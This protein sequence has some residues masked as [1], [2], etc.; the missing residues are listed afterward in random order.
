MAF[1]D[2][3]HGEGLQAVNESHRDACWSAVAKVAGS[4]SVR[5]AE[6]LVAREPNSASQWIDR[7]I[8]DYRLHPE[9]HLALEKAYGIHVTVPHFRGG[10]PLV[11]SQWHLTEDYRLAWEL[12]LF[13]VGARKYFDTNALHAFANDIDPR[14]Y[15]WRLELTIAGI[16][17][18]PHYVLYC[19]SKQMRSHDPKAARELISTL[20][21]LKSVNDQ[22]RPDTSNKEFGEWLLSL[23]RGSM[24]TTFE[25]NLELLRSE[26]GFNGT[27][28]LTLVTEIAKVRERRARQK[29]GGGPPE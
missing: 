29:G 27:T 15:R 2:T 18:F 7:L 25:Q 8:A 12:R 4:M 10:F 17:D 14:I 9:V 3:S 24:S 16:G 6:R 26:P 22:R 1:R 5:E 19:V 20:E 21:I 11:P 23:A 28:A 13:A